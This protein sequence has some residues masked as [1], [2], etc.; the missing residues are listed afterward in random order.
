M[1]DGCL[2]ARDR[3]VPSRPQR[4]ADGPATCP[5]LTHADAQTAAPTMPAL[6]QA[7]RARRRCECSEQST[8]QPVYRLAR[9]SCKAMMHEAPAW[10]AA[11]TVSPRIPRKPPECDPGG[12]A[13]R[14]TERIPPV[15]DS[16]RI[17]SLAHQSM[18]RP[19]FERQKQQQGNHKDHDHCGRQV[20]LWRRLMLFSHRLLRHYRCV[21]DSSHSCASICTVR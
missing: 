10:R 12:G 4:H 21:S 5:I 9:S 13:T 18:R 19:Q 15:P 3:G 1:M 8:R 7:R 11:L 14:L 20:P 2:P 6:R 16:E 17:E